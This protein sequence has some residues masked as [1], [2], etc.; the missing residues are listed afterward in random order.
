MCDALSRCRRNHHIHQ[1]KKPNQ[2]CMV[3]NNNYIFSTCRP[4]TNLTN[5]MCV[6][7]SR[8]TGHGVYM[9]TSMRS[10]L[11]DFF[12]VYLPSSDIQMYQKSILC[13]ACILYINGQNGLNVYS[14]VVCYLCF[15]SECYSPR[16]M[17]ICNNIA[18]G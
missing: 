8:G 11:L 1:L 4:Q 10:F 18:L 13:I 14:S 2:L 9:L 15:E 16:E 7:C 12:S 6:L 3:M 5:R 17:Q